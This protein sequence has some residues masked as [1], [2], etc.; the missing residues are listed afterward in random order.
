MNMYYKGLTLAWSKKAAFLDQ[1]KSIKI[2]RKSVE[3]LIKSYRKSIEN[4]HRL[5]QNWTRRL[6][7]PK[8][9]EHFK[10]HL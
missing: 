5:V 8:V 2:C 10:K 1:A 3:N 4:H 6:A 9:P 7:Y